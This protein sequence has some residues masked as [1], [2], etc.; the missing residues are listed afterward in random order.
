[1]SGQATT[2]ANPITTYGSDATKNQ[3]R[4]GGDLGTGRYYPIVN[5]STGKID[6]YRYVD[7]N[8][9]QIGSIPRKGNFVPNTQSSSAETSHFTST[10]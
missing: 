1:M 10:T 8:S 7:G 4:P 9:T 2:T 6:V 3:I 5:A